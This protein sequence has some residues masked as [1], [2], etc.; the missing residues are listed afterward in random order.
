MSVKCGLQSQ[1]H[2]KLVKPERGH[3]TSIDGE[4][5]TLMLIL[6]ATKYR[7]QAVHVGVTRWKISLPSVRL[8]FCEVLTLE[9]MHL[10]L[11][12]MEL[13]T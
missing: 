11:A 10:L 12:S 6:V 3:V 5:Q 9:S 4:I 13:L 1:E 2:I 8:R 7:L